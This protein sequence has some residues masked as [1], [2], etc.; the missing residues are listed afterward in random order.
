MR[1][2]NNRKS[3]EGAHK[4]IY[5]WYDNTGEYISGSRPL[6]FVDGKELQQE[7]TRLEVLEDIGRIEK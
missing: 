7:V 3:K 5:Y 4:T 1:V 2:K 6:F